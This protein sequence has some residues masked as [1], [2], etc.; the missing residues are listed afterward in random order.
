M[1]GYSGYSMSNNAVQAYNAGEMPLSKWT[2]KKFLELLPTII[3]EG[4]DDGYPVDEDV[5]MKLS[6]VKWSVLKEEFL[7]CSSY[8]HT[9]SYYNATDFYDVASDKIYELKDKD[10]D[11]L[12]QKKES[13]CKKDPAKEEHWECK[14]L[15]WSGTKS[16]PKAKEVTEVGV[17]RGNWFYRKDGSKKSITANGF[18]KIR[19]I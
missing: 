1:A 2:K 6:K 9:S 18:E 17:I 5:V 19:K 8:H 16:H 7:F 10:I 15:V 11:E 3:Q 13:R 14:F 12:M 4:I